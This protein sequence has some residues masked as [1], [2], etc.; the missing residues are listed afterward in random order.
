MLNIDG[1]LRIAENRIREAH[2][3]GK[4]ENL[5]GMGQPLNLTDNAMVPPSQRAA[6]HI[7]KN[8]GVLPEWAQLQRDI[9]IEQQTVFAMPEKVANASMAF[10]GRRMGTSLTLEEQ[11]S[12]WRTNERARFADRI[13]A[14]N[15]MVLKLCLVGP[16]NFITVRPL[17]T[18]A[19]LDQFDELVSPTL[20]VVRSTA[21]HKQ[22]ARSG[23]PTMESFTTAVRRWFVTVLTVYR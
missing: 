10:T 4:F 19:L 7:L 23:K 13:K 18:R 20:P 6:S 16:Q 22:S 3:E 11:Y 14:C 17:N 21:A 15:H 5:P 1:I 9:D 8:A 12:A 2:E